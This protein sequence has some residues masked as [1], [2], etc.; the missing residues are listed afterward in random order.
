MQLAVM[1]K[2][3]DLGSSSS[4]EVFKNSEGIVISPDDQSIAGLTYLS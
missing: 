3:D 4:T 1:Q 2:T